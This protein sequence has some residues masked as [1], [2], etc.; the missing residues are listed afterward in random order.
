[1]RHV[2]RERLEIELRYYALQDDSVVYHNPTIT[3]GIYDTIEEAVAAGNEM[4][5]TLSKYFKVRVGDTFKVN[6]LLGYPDRLVSNCCY[7]TNGVVYFARIVRME[8]ADVEAK[9]KQAIQSAQEL[10]MKE[11]QEEDETI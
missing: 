6:G 2:I 8:F 10:R 3:V 1:M 7:R 9:V 11:N 4:L 5:V